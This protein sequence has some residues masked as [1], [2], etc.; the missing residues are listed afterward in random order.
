MAE[1]STFEVGGAPVGSLPA[2][3]WEDNPAAMPRAVPR[4][5][6]PGNLPRRRR[7]VGRDDALRALEEAL[8]GRASSQG[9]GG[10]ATLYGLAGAGK[11]ALALEYAHRA[12]ALGAYPGGTFWLS[13][14]GPRSRLWRGSTPTCAPRRPRR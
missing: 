12:A 11:T 1:A 6:V 13:A 10:V 4:A 7:F 3:P 9:H 8:G 2:M 5:P 14:E